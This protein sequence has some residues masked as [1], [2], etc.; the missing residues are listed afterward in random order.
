MRYRYPTQPGATAWLSPMSLQRHWNCQRHPP[1]VLYKQQWGL[2]SAGVTLPRQERAPPAWLRQAK[3]YPQAERTNRFEIPFS[4]P[5]WLLL[6]LS[7]Y[8][9]L[10][11]VVR[12]FVIE[13]V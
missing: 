6:F 7:V 2:P 1:R 13:I 8:R 11:K 4:W 9:K 12:Q 3:A 5:A 10:L